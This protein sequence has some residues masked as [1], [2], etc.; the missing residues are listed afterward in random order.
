M[1]PGRDFARATDARAGC[2]RRGSKKR[3]ER[4][5][6]AEEVPRRGVSNP[7]FRNRSQG[8]SNTQTRRQQG[9]PSPFC[10]RTSRCARTQR[11][12]PACTSSPESRLMGSKPEFT[13]AR[14]TTR[15]SQ[16]SARALRPRA[17]RAQKDDPAGGSVSLSP[18]ARPRARRAPSLQ[19]GGSSVLVA[20]IRTFRRRASPDGH[21]DRRGP[22]AP[23]P[24]PED[25]QHPRHGPQL[26]GAVDRERSDPP[27]ASGP[28]IASV[29]PE[30]RKP[31]LG[32]GLGNAAAALQKACSRYRSLNDLREGNH[33]VVPVAAQ[34]RKSSPRRETSSTAPSTS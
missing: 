8:D 3:G 33:G 6:P 4:I 15:R 14:S 5:P 21:L 23:N 12:G 28:S 25:D 1:R 26:E 18:C 27:L 22:H 29:E 20:R 30:E 11:E 34:E 24:H 17:L 13:P 7:M 32:I 19:H 16:P 9:R 10:D 31:V 2:L